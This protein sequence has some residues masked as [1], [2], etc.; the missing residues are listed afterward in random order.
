MDW[1]HCVP[2]TTGVSVRQYIKIGDVLKERIL[3]LI[4]DL[5]YEAR[6]GGACYATTAISHSLLKLHNIDSTPCIGVV[7]CENGEIFDHAWLEIDGLI[8]D[9]ALPFPQDQSSTVYN[10]FDDRFGFRGVEN[11]ES[12]AYGTD[13]DLN[14]Q[15]QLVA[16]DFNFIMEQTPF[17]NP[18]LNYWELA[19]GLSDATEKSATVEELKNITKD[20]KW[21]ERRKKSG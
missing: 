5:I 11:P 13:R 2:P 19:S 9:L 8:Y 16:N 21:T 3:D 12:F 15:A 20:C 7:E 18:R 10:Y 17:F 4:S 6:W 1:L 14:Q